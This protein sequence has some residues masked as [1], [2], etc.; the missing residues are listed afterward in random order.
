MKYLLVIEH[1]GLLETEA[2]DES[3]QMNPIVIDTGRISSQSL[4]R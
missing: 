1:P 2:K 3:Y 4:E